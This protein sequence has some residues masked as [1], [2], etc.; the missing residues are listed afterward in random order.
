MSTEVLSI[1]HSPAV[2]TP[3]GW[4]MAAAQANANASLDSRWFH[5]EKNDQNVHKNNSYNT[6][7]FL[8]CQTYAPSMLRRYIDAKISPKKTTP[9][10]S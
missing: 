6:V 2:L 1:D 9:V 4:K 5:R 7:H 8:S 10:C 3:T